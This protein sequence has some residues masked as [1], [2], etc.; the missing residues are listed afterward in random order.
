MALEI[1]DIPK[2]DVLMILFLTAPVT[3]VVCLVHLPALGQ[4]RAGVQ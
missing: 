2:I 4:V 3:R 1:Q